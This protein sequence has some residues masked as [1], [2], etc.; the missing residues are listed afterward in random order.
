[1]LISP[2]HWHRVGIW[3]VG[4]RA[5]R[6]RCVL[7]SGCG[8]R[9]R[10][11]WNGSRGSCKWVLGRTC[12]TCCPGSG[13]SGSEMKKSQLCQCWFCWRT[14]GFWNGIGLPESVLEFA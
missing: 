11:R 3:S 8:R 12:R 6:R 5:T 13:G 7:R 9:R 4:G 1:M 10:W 14:P 2:K